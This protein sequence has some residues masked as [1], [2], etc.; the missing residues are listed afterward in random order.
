M[1]AG[2]EIVGYRD[3]GVLRPWGE[4][5][6]NDFDRVPQNKHVMIDITQRRNVA[7][8][9]KMWAIFQRV[10]ECCPGFDDA[11][12]VC[13]WVKIKLRMVKA[14]KDWG[15]GRIIVRTKSISFASLDQVRFSAFY[16]RAIWL[17]SEHIGI[18][19]ESLLTGED[20]GMAAA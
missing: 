14:Y 13:E 12:D 4:A 19:P 20:S 3:G 5:S 6:W 8:H 15:D 10:A 18:D 9:N 11:E 1:S 7:H 17:L 16:D 2:I